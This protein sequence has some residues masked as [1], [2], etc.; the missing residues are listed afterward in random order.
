MTVVP[1]TAARAAVQALVPD[2]P[3][4]VEARAMALDDNAWALASKD[5]FVIGSDPAR[6]LVGVGPATARDAIA[7]L[8]ERAGWTLLAAITRDD[9]VAAARAIGRTAARAVIA[10][11]PEPDDLPDLDGAT[12]LGRDD[13]LA[14]LAPA[15]ADELAV[16]IAR[17]HQVWC[18]RV[19]GKPV[20]FAYAPWRSE[21]W[22]DVSVDTAPGYRQLG[23]ATVVAATM[24]RGEYAHGREAV[25]GADEDNAGSLRLAHRLGF[26]A[27][28]VALWVI[29]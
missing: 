24:I 10:T 14:H 25:W 16:A 11:L 23:L 26:A 7:A 18:A 2:A 20:S 27:P 28:H 13:D 19:E 4:W 1:M 29:A 8:A 3:E 5:G 9:V 17:G 15:L 21:R 6:L 22:F 12:L